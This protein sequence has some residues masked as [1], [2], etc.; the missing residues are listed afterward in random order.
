MKLN[1]LTTA[2]LLALLLAFL[3]LQSGVSAHQTV[4]VGPYNVEI[5]WLDEPPIVGQMNA[6]VMN[7]SNQR[8]KRHSG[9]GAPSPA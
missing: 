4:T 1:K 2:C 3:G 5:G 9:D 8:W 6:I 7:L